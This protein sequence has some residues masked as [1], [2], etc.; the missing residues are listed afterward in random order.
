MDIKLELVLRKRIGRRVDVLDDRG[1]HEVAGW[2]R[3]RGDERFASA[4]DAHDVFTPRVEREHGLKVETPA[5]DPVLTQDRWSV[6]P[7]RDADV[8]SARVHRVHHFR[9]EARDLDLSVDDSDADVGR[10]ATR[11]GREKKG[12]AAHEA[13]PPAFQCDAPYG[14]ATFSRFSEPEAVR[15]RTME[16]LSSK[17]SS[18]SMPVIAVMVL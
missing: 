11:P 14:S 18:C 4:V 2:K 16:W 12:D 10:C 3:N 1:G 17:R 8:C 9:R 7:D 13:T 6:G 15:A 5:G